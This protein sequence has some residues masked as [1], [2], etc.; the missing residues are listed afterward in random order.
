MNSRKNFCL[1]YF[2]DTD[3]LK[4]EDENRFTATEAAWLLPVKGTDIYN[5]F[6]QANPWVK[7]WYP[8][9]KMRD[10]EVCKPMK[11]KFFKRASEWF[12]GGKVGSSLDTW[13]MKRTLKRWQKKF[14][15][16]EPERFE[17]A[18]RSRKYV[19]KHHPLDYQ[20]KVFKRYNDKAKQFE[21]QFE[22]K[23]S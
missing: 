17:L 11:R 14:G 20:N 10:E 4:V 19:S 16:M 15:H 12:L 3:H 7:N 23:L 1:N 18:L 6:Q 9:F 8:N 5:D 2:L 21:E 13:C 22:V